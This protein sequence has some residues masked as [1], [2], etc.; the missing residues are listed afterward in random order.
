MKTTIRSNHAALAICAL[1]ALLCLTFVLSG[2]KKETAPSAGK[3]LVPTPVVELREK[4]RSESEAS[5]LAE[6]RAENPPEPQ[7]DR[8]DNDEDLITIENRKKIVALEREER[9]LL[10][11]II[12]AKT[13][14][15]L[16]AQNENIET[17]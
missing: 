16:T 15:V 3:V 6:V 10:E 12:A 9:L 17:G 4:V 7:G 13:G 1:A 11:T 8:A 2:R 5:H 14:S